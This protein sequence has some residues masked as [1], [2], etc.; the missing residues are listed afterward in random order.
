MTLY[1]MQMSIVNTYLTSKF[2][3]SMARFTFYSTCPVLFFRY[4][5]RG[6]KISC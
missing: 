4:A 5:F 3:R 6:Q 1:I 2:F